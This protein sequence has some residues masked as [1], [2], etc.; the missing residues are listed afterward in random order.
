V[1]ESTAAVTGRGPIDVINGT[2][3]IHRTLIDGIDHSPNHGN[4][5]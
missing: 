3:V 4:W 5:I 1:D 2:D